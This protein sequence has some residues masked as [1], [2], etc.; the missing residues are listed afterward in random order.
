VGGSWWHR[1]AVGCIDLVAQRFGDIQAHLAEFS[2]TEVSRGT[3]SRVT[4]TV[5]EALHALPAGCGRCGDGDC[6]DRR[7]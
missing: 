5:L 3:M 1:H 6:I 2:D 4:D 7:V